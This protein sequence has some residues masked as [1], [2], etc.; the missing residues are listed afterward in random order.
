MGADLLILGCHIISTLCSQC[1]PADRLGECTE[2]K[3]AVCPPTC[4]PGTW[5]PTGHEPCEACEI[6]SNTIYF[7]YSNLR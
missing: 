1:S 4:G 3:D 6:C 7:H 5:S 2:T